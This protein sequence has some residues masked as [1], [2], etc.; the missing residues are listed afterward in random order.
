[1][2]GARAIEISQRRRPETAIIP[3]KCEIGVAVDLTGI[4]LAV[5]HIRTKKI[6]EHDN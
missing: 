5:V 6:Y 4:C 2:A 1:M 3:E